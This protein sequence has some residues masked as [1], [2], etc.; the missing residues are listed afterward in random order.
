LKRWLPARKFTAVYGLNPKDPQLAEI[1]QGIKQLN[2]IRNRLAHNLSAAVTTED[3]AIFLNAKIFA[4]MRIEG[5]KPRNPSQEPLDILEQFAQYASTALSNEF[6]ELG[7]AFGR[8][9]N[10]LPPPLAT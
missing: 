5:A 7:K 10:E 4:A 2:S 1:L 3:A 6:S 8:A 9:L